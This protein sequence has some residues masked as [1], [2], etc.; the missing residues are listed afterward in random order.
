MLG[1]EKDADDSKIKNAYRRLAVRFHPDKNKM[2]GNTIFN[3]GAKQAFH[4]ISNA[5]TTLI[6]KH[7]RESYDRF[8]P[9]EEVLQKEAA[10]RHREQHFPEGEEFDEF[11]FVF[12]QF[13]GGAMPRGQ[14]Y[15]YLIVLTEL[16]IRRADQQRRSP[17]GW[18]EHAPLLRYNDARDVVHPQTVRVDPLLLVAA[19]GRVHPAEGDIGDEDG[20]LRQEGP[21]ELCGGTPR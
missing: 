17:R 9:N 18:L 11:E 10:R 3:S 12:R 20:I 14:T 4:K 19:G 21:A 8:G 1:I 7:S 5:Y 15:Q 16:S 13:F 2:E 6:D